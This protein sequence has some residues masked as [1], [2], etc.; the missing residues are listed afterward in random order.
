LYYVDILLYFLIYFQDQEIDEETEVLVLA[1]DGLW[2]VVQNEVRSV[3]LLSPA[4][5]VAF[6]YIIRQELFVI[7]H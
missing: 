2:D 6:T 4:L 7:T 1:S 3:F 5:L